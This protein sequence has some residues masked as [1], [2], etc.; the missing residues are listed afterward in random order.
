M[1]QALNSGPWA[2]QPALLSTEPSSFQPFNWSIKA[3]DCDWAVEG[4]VWLEALERGGMVREEG[5]RK[6]RWKEDG[7][8]L[9]GQRSPK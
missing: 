8:E 4:K 6:K 1:C 3:K 9:L 7:A 2:E 5:Q